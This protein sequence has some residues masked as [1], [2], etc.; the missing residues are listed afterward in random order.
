ML[1]VLYLWHWHL[2]HS[3]IFC[4]FPSSLLLG[5]TRGVFDGSIFED[6]LST[7][8]SRFLSLPA[9]QHLHGH[10]FLELACLLIAGDTLDTLLKDSERFALFS[11]NQTPRLQRCLLQPVMRK[12]F[13]HLDS[14]KSYFGVCLEGLSHLPKVGALYWLQS[15]NMTLSRG[16][17]TWLAFW[18]ASNWKLV[19]SIRS[20]STA[21][22]RRVIELSVIRVFTLFRLLNCD[23]NV[24]SLFSK[25]HKHC[26][27]K[28]TNNKAVTAGVQRISTWNPCVAFFS[29]L[30][31]L[32]KICWDKIKGFTESF[33]EVRFLNGIHNTP[34]HDCFHVFKA[35]VCHFLVTNGNKWNKCTLHRNRNK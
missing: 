25:S 18:A 5:V 4:V 26:I 7:L 30:E 11:C 19:R 24:M 1:G 22:K 33:S 6:I 9:I 27:H 35:A 13:T 21:L 3:Y 8:I 16:V 15:L 29:T 12:E 14:K 20:L 2:N 32:A 34:H 23:T 17:L 31:W 10:T 28:W